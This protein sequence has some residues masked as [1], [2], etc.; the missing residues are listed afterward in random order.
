M[1]VLETFIKLRDDMI[2]WVT[3]NLKQKVNKEE[4]KSLS[5]NDYTNDEKAKLSTVVDLVGD[6]SLLPYPD[7]SITYNMQQIDKKI[8]EYNSEDI[9]ALQ[10]QL[11]GYSIRVLSEEE[12]ANLGTYDEKTIYCCY[13]ENE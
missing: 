13:N 3:N 10:N 12:Y 5:T 4:G 2:L 6:Q 8:A 7:D 11:N 1:T 9:I